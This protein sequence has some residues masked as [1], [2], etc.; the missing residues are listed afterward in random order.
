VTP[1]ELMEMAKRHHDGCDDETA[2]ALRSYAELTACLNWLCAE[3]DA[4]VTAVE[5]ESEYVTASSCTEP[6]AL[7]Q[8]AR[9][10]GWPVLEEA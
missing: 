7:M 3:K 4:L 10:L 8:L 1:S 2:A 6:A 9:D 5:S